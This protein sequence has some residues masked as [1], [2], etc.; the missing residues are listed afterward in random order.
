M[1]DESKRAEEAYCFAYYSELKKLGKKFP[2]RI[3]RIFN[4]YG[5]R[6]DVQ[7]TSQYGRVLIKFLVQA[8]KGELVT[9]YGDGLQTRSFCYVTDQ[10]VGLFKMLLV[11]NIEGE[12]INIGND[13]E[14][15][16]LELAKEIIKVTR[17]DSF[18]KLK[19]TPS[20]Q[21]EGD[22]QRRC[23]D[24]SKARKLINFS[25]AVEL[26]EGLQRTSFWAK[27]NLL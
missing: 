12:V 3:A 4:T 10:I 1:Y 18:I 5:P 21:L 19:S 24:I 16:I 26:E 13:K 17:S 7:W 23:P 15:T 14:M 8:L 25:N 27:Q 22:P 9:V 20:Y 11:E 6:L 2:V